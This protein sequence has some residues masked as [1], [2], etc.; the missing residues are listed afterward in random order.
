MGSRNADRLNDPPDW[1]S[2]RTLGQMKAAGWRLATWCKK[3]GHG[4][5][6]DLDHL[7]ELRGAEASPWD[8]YIVCGYM[9]CRGRAIFKAATGPADLWFRLTRDW[10]GAA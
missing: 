8:R 1:H 7:I 2:V 5:P 3:C 9:S 4:A 6:V 10:T